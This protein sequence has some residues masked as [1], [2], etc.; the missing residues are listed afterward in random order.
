MFIQTEIGLLTYLLMLI[1]NTIYALINIL[2]HLYVL[3][4][5]PFLLVIS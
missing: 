4:E 3:A 1:K 2:I 5:M